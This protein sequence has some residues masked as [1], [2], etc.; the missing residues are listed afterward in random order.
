MDNPLIS[1]A[2]HFADYLKHIKEV[3]ISW[4]VKQKDQENKDLVEV[5]HLLVN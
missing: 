4:S 2:S 5:E 1:L 3:S